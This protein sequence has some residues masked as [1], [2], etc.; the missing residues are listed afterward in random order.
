MNWITEQFLR[1][2]G[3]ILFTARKRSGLFFLFAIML[4]PD[5]GL[6]GLLGAVLSI[7]IAEYVCSNKIWQHLGFFGAAGLLSGMALSAYL[8]GGYLLLA[9][10]PVSSM[11]AVLLVL[12]FTPLLAER[13]LPVLALPFVVTSLISIMAAESMGINFNIH[14]TPEWFLPQLNNLEIWLNDNLPQQITLYLKTFGSL[15]FVPGIIPGLLVFTGIL[16]G[17]RITAVAM[18]AGGIV[19]TTLFSLFSTNVINSGELG[20]VAFNSVLV[21]A[22]MVGI[23][24]TLSLRGLFYALL[25][26]IVSVLISAGLDSVMA[27]LG[28]PVLALPFCITVWLF[29]YPLKNQTLSSMRIKVWAPPLNLVGR[30]EANLRGFERWKRNQEKPLP[31]LSLPLHGIW[32]VTQGPNGKVTHNTETGSQA[33][34]FMLFEDDS[35]ATWPGEELDQFHGYGCPVHATADGVVVAMDGT[36]ADNQVHQIDTKAPWGNWVMIAHTEGNVSLLAHLRPGTLCVTNGQYV[37]RGQLVAQVGNSGRSPEPH[38][39]FQLN[40]AAWFESPSLPARFGSWVEV[41][42]NGDHIFH[43]LGSPEE[44]QLVASLEHFYWSD[45]SMY[46]PFA[47]SGKSEEY[48]IKHGHKTDVIELKTIAGSWGRLLLDD[49]RRRAQIIYWPGWIQLLAID[50]GDPDWVPEI[51]GSLVELLL[52]YCP[53]LPLKGIDGF[54]VSGDYFSTSLSRGFRRIFS[55]EDRAEYE[56]L[57]NKDIESSG[58]DCITNVEASNSKKSIAEFRF[59]VSHGVETMQIVDFKSNRIEIKRIEKEDAN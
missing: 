56:M 57:F 7:V 43:P 42:D 40:S 55:L 41:C 18:I 38:L 36:Q 21:S 9:L 1:S 32:K 27:P 3:A 37:K 51:K 49:G 33:W 26:I 48:E 31:V 12:V 20:L 50:E 2:T 25:A 39:H 8:D 10:M 35:P 45:W 14:H 53:A 28:L 22:A 23:F 30:A 11:L 6:V 47:V 24:V 52:L 44:G 29:L 16:I 17:S 34:D 46:M 54:K 19:G 59:R 15:L 5:H 13:D 58:L 4:A